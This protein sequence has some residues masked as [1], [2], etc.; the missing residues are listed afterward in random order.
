M[1]PLI[2]AAT[3]AFGVPDLGARIGEAAAAEQALRGPL[4]GVAMRVAQG[5][6]AVFALQ[7]SDPIDG[8]L[9]GA[10]RDMATGDLGVIDGGSRGGGLIHLKLTLHGQERAWLSLR[11]AGPDR[12]RGQ[13]LAEGR[14]VP[15]AL[16]RDRS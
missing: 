12:W 7:V 5:P 6:G 14:A 13:M 11:P 10:W 9:G 3:L 16:A 1:A 4:D 15:V 2:A 8:P